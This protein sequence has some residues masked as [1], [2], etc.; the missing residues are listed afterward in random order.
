MD[1]GI[2][3]FITQYWVHQLDEIIQEMNLLVRLDSNTWYYMTKGE[4]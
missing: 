3:F 4:N 2:A 1:L